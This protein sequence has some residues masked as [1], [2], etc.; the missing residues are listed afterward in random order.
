[1]IAVEN[2]TKNYGP[3]R[4]LQGI[5]FGADRGQILG[6]LGPNGAGKTTTMRIMTGYLRPTSGTVRIDGLDILEEPLEAKKKIGYLPEFAPLYPEMLVRDHLEH[7]ARL[8]G[9]G[10]EATARRIPELAGLCGLRDVMH[11]PFRQLS[12]GYKQRVG[13]AHAMVSDPEILILDEPT[14]GLDP[15]Q[16]VEIRA[17][18][19]EMGRRKT[20]IFSTHI[21]SEA[22]A[23]C[24]RIV[25]ID[26]GRIVADGTP[27]SLKSSLTARQLV[28]V[29][30]RGPAAERAR[31]ELAALP[32]VM[33]V[34]E[35]PPAGPGELRL[36]LACSADA[37]EAVYRRIKG[38]DWVLLELSMEGFSFEDV[39]REITT[40]H[41]PQP[42]VPKGAAAEKRR[43]RA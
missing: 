39:F 11:R 37:R 18:I 15:N 42:E 23:T 24:D 22:E 10:A 35:L 33:E 34:R 8:R 40:A 31:A 27:G 30:L 25:I 17:I 36:Q 5:S 14:S 21:L 16:I 29:S 41:R 38:E 1:V 26:R 12:R 4:A 19:R 2:L 9:L 3:T 28:R 43:S 32:D 7:A 6:L 13:L 20:V